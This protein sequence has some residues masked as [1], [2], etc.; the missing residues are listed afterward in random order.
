MEEW[1]NLDK[2]LKGSSYEWALALKCKGM[3]QA[4]KETQH[5]SILARD[6]CCCFMCL[7]GYFVFGVHEAWL[8]LSDIAQVQYY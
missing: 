3:P 8:V 6:G 1:K 2:L 5:S 7:D 4:K